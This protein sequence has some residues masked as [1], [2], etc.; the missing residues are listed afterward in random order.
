MSLL[1]QIGEAKFWPYSF[2]SHQVF[3]QEMKILTRLARNRQFQFPNHRK[4]SHIGSSSSSRCNLHGPRMLYEKGMAILP[5]SAA[6]PHPFQGRKSCVAQDHGTLFSTAIR[7]VFDRA[8][9]WDS[10]HSSRL[11]KV[12]QRRGVLQ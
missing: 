8:I 5:L 6:F 4:D 9:E 3:N 1:S 10:H 2:L 7:L 11:K 12:A